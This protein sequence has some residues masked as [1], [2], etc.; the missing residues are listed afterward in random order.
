MPTFSKLDQVGNNSFWWRQFAILIWKFIAGSEA[1]YLLCIEVLWHYN[2]YFSSETHCFTSFGL[3]TKLV[4]CRGILWHV[5]L[6]SNKA[7]IIEFL[8]PSLDHHCPG[9]LKCKELVKAAVDLSHVAR[10]HHTVN[11]INCG[12]WTQMHLVCLNKG[13]PGCAGFT[14]IGILICNIVYNVFWSRGMQ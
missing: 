12:F 2:Y 4:F 1:S 10:E 5:F 8:H 3:F 9:P 11:S 14:C 7:T 13:F 6:Q